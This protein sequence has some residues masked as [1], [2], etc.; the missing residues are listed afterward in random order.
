MSKARLER[1]D[2]TYDLVYEGEKIT[3]DGVVD[4]SSSD[5]AY[6]KAWDEIF[7]VNGLEE[8]TLFVDEDG[9]EDFLPN[10]FE[11]HIELERWQTEY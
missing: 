10:D 3:G 8:G 2:Y 7:Q 4:A 6:S 9:D 1:F 5:D 11:L